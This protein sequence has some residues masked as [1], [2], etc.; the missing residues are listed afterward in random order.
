GIK[1]LE[2]S[3]GIGA[4]RIDLHPTT[5]SN[6]LFYA[7]S[8]PFEIPLGSLIPVRI[9]NL[10]PACKNIG[11][12][13]V[14]NGCFRVHPVEWNIGEAAGTLAAFSINSD[15]SLHEIYNSPDRIKEYQSL[16]VD[17]GISLHWPE[18]TTI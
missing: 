15:I 5:K 11:T 14:T 7:K 12:T 6:R 8:Y 13:Q 2:N 18:I 4:Y 9:K 1:T 16:L 10:I 3:V 17:R